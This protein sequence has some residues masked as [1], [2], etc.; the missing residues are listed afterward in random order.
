MMTQEEQ[1]KIEVNLKL[2]VA[3]INLI[4]AA[5]D[6]MPHKTVRSTVDNLMNQAQSQVEKIIAEMTT[7]EEMPE[8]SPVEEQ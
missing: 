1:L 2:T 4:L 7:Q 8:A 6:E 5:M 3:E